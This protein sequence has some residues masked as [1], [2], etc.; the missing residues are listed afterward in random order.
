MGVACATHAHVAAGLGENVPR[1]LHANAA[2]VRWWW[3]WLGLGAGGVGGGW[4]VSLRGSVVG[5][6]GVNLRGSA[7]DVV[8][9]GLRRHCAHLSERRGF[10]PSKLRLGL[11]RA[12]QRPLA[13][14]GRCTQT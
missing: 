5:V 11:G 2:C 7:V 12:A 13:S 4:R 10:S 9:A 14:R 1:T 8:G 6:V 3:R